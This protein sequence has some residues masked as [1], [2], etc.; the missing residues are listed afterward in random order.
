MRWFELPRT[1]WL[2]LLLLLLLP[3]LSLG[4]WQKAYERSGAEGRQQK[5]KQSALV[6]WL[7]RRRALSLSSRDP[8]KQSL[9][10]RAPSALKLTSGPSTVGPLSIGEESNHLRE[11]RAFFAGS[12]DDSF[13]F[14]GPLASDAEE[15]A[16]ESLSERAALQRRDRTPDILPL[17][18]SVNELNSS[19]S[20]S[21][22][23]VHLAEGVTERSTDPLRPPSVLSLSSAAASAEGGDATEGRG[24]E[25]EGQL[26]ETESL[27]RGSYASD[28]GCGM[29]G[30]RSEF[31]GCLSLRGIR[32]V[33]ATYSEFMKNSITNAISGWTLSILRKA[34][35]ETLRANKMKKGTGSYFSKLTVLGQVDD[36]EWVLDEHKATEKMRDEGVGLLDAELV[37]PPFHFDHIA[38][39]ALHGDPRFLRDV[40]E[41]LRETAW[42]LR[43]DEKVKKDWEEKNITPDSPSD[44]KFQS[45][46]WPLSLASIGCLNHELSFP[47]QP[48]CDPFALL[49]VPP[50]PSVLLELR[51]I[52]EGAVLSPEERERDIWEEKQRLDAIWNPQPKASA[53]LEET[54][55]HNVSF[56]S[57]EAKATDELLGEVPSFSFSEAKKQKAPKLFFYR[58]EHLISLA[59]SRQSFAVRFFLE[60]WGDHWRPRFGLP[61]KIALTAKFGPISMMEKFIQEWRDHPLLSKGEDHAD[62]AKSGIVKAAFCPSVLQTPASA[63]PVDILWKTWEGNDRVAVGQGIFSDALL[64]SGGV[65]Q[66]ALPKGN[67]LDALALTV[68]KLSDVFHADGTPVVRVPPPR[69]PS[70]GV[71]CGDAKPRKAGTAKGCVTAALISRSGFGTHQRNQ[72][73]P[74]DCG[75]GAPVHIAAYR[76]D[77]VALKTLVEF[78]ADIF[79]KDHLNRTVLHHIDLSTSTKSVGTMYLHVRSLALWQLGILGDETGPPSLQLFPQSLC[80]TSGEGTK[81]GNETKG[82]AQIHRLSSHQQQKSVIQTED[83]DCDGSRQLEVLLEE[84]AFG[85]RPGFYTFMRGR[86]WEAYIQYSATISQKPPKDWDSTMQMRASSTMFGFEPIGWKMIKSDLPA[87][88]GITTLKR[89]FDINP[90]NYSDSDQASLLMWALSRGYLEIV[91]TLWTPRQWKQKCK[92]C[93]FLLGLEDKNEGGNMMAGS[94]PIHIL[95]FKAHQLPDAGKMFTDLLA[96]AGDLLIYTPNDYGLRPIQMAAGITG[97]EELLFLMLRLKDRG[98]L[99]D[100]GGR[101]ELFSHMITDLLY[102]RLTVWQG[103]KSLPESVGVSASLPSEE[104]PL[105]ESVRVRRSQLELSRTVSDVMEDTLMMLLKYLRLYGGRVDPLF[106]SESPSNPAPCLLREALKA[107]TFLQRD[108]EERVELQVGQREGI[109]DKTQTT[110]EVSEDDQEDRDAAMEFIE[111]TG[112]GGSTQKQQTSRQVNLKKHESLEGSQKGENEDGRQGTDARKTEAGRET[113]TGTGNAVSDPPSHPDTKLNPHFFFR[114]EVEEG[115]VLSSEWMRVEVMSRQ[116]ALMNPSGCIDMD[117]AGAKN[118]SKNPKGKVGKNFEEMWNSPVEVDAPLIACDLPSALWICLKHPSQQAAAGTNESVCAQKDEDETSMESRRLNKRLRA[119]RCALLLRPF[120]SSS[121]LHADGG[122]RQAGETTGTFVEKEFEPEDG[123]ASGKTNEEKLKSTQQKNT[124][125]PDGGT[126]ELCKRRRWLPE[127]LGDTSILSLRHIYIG[128]KREEDSVLK[129]EGGVRPLLT[130]FSDEALLEG[131]RGED[132]EISEWRDEMENWNSALLVRLSGDMKMSTDGAPVALPRFE[133][134]DQGETTGNGTEAERRRKKLLKGPQ[135]LSALNLHTSRLVL[136]HLEIRGAPS[137]CV[138]A[139][140]SEVILRN[141]RMSR[142]GQAASDLGLFPIARDRHRGARILEPLGGEVEGTTELGRPLTSTHLSLSLKFTIDPKTAY[143]MGSALMLIYNNV[144]EKSSVIQDCVFEDNAGG[145]QG[146]AVSVLVGPSVAV[147]RTAGLVIERSTMRRNLARVKGGALAVSSF[148]KMPRAFHV[149]IR[150][151]LFE[152]NQALPDMARFEA[153]AAML[154]EAE[155]E[156]LFFDLK[157]HQDGQGDE[158]KTEPHSSSSSSS[159]KTPTMLAAFILATAKLPGGDEIPLG[160]SGAIHSSTRITQKIFEDL[161]GRVGDSFPSLEILN[162]TLRNNGATN[163][164]GALGAFATHVK[165]SECS[166]ENNYLDS[167]IKPADNVAGALS[168]VQSEKRA[169]GTGVHLKKCTFEGNQVFAKGKYMAT[170]APDAFSVRSHGTIEMSSGCVAVTDVENSVVARAEAS[171][172]SLLRLE[173]LMTVCPHGHTAQHDRQRTGAGAIRFRSECTQCESPTFLIGR[174]STMGFQ[175]GSSADQ[176]EAQKRNLEES[177]TTQ[178]KGGTGQPLSSDSASS[179][180]LSHVNRCASDC[181]LGASCRLGKNNVLA[182]PGFWC[183][184]TPPSSSSSSVD[185]VAVE[186]K[187]C[188][189]GDK[190]KCFPSYNTE[191]RC[192]EESKN[193]LKGITTKDRGGLSE[194][195]TSPSGFLQMPPLPAA[196]TQHLGGEVQASES[197]S[198]AFLGGSSR[199]WRA[200]PVSSFVSEGSTATRHPLGFSALESAQGPQAGGGNG[201]GSGISVR[202]SDAVKFD[203]TSSCHEHTDGPFCAECDQ[204]SGFLTFVWSLGG[205]FVC[206]QTC[207]RELSDADLLAWTLALGFSAL[208]RNLFFVISGASNVGVMKSLLFFSNAVLILDLAPAGSGASRIVRRVA[209]GLSFFLQMEGNGSEAA[210]GEKLTWWQQLSVLCAG[211]NFSSLHLLFFPL[212]K[213]LVFPSVLLVMLLFHFLFASCGSSSSSTSHANEGGEME[214]AEADRRAVQGPEEDCEQGEGQGERGALL[215]STERGGGSEEGSVQG[216]FEKLLDILDRRYMQ[217]FAFFVIDF[218]PTWLLLVAKALRCQDLPGGGGR[219]VWSAPV[220][221]CSALW[222]WPALGVLVLLALVPLGLFVFVKRAVTVRE[223]RLVRSVLQMLESCFKEKFNWWD[224]NFLLRRLLLVF[225]VSFVPGDGRQRALAQAVLAL[226][227]TAQTICEP[228]RRGLDNICEVTCLLILIFLCGLKRGDKATRAMAFDDAGENAGWLREI[229][230]LG[231]SVLLTVPYVFLAV[232]YVGKAQAAVSLSEGG[233]FLGA[234]GEGV[235]K[236]EESAKSS[237]SNSRRRELEEAGPAGR[238]GEKMERAVLEGRKGSGGGRD[239][240]TPAEGDM[241]R[242][243]SGQDKQA[244]DS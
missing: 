21:V 79:R 183:V 233:D 117:R 97:T 243:L 211:S 60:A 33:D 113:R 83:A 130:C 199:Q 134:G 52:I 42:G 128:P 125:G 204:G 191:E 170:G 6:R 166:F 136:D 29:T 17:S 103:E 1:V 205:T 235:L 151:S 51:E 54:G 80:R 108:A 241:E 36:P 94:L 28:G 139:I 176:F 244:A 126:F 110:G 120:A 76:G 65:F 8:G 107:R 9:S 206:H 91:R 161:A 145:F 217:V 195:S 231:V 109:D 48:R 202:C 219:V 119:R 180:S 112:W 88:Q 22:P 143:L 212:W 71:C 196:L 122:R 186:C 82:E 93:R 148:A 84:D 209:M 192:R 214:E 78:G 234:G 100:T 133:L 75:S 26:E 222:W 140:D 131:K 24:N 11:R 203:G 10:A 230:L 38:L 127:L 144:A 25:P 59:I 172:D 30:L 184:H 18:E 98:G 223:W 90:D 115:A 201:G 68:R 64:D 56:L 173:G 43:E 165:L 23:A 149:D 197:A 215:G 7:Q 13:R 55:K 236:E 221:G 220:Q 208:A 188:P 114:G 73:V 106:L 189:P 178:R 101:A 105:R 152:G 169:W 187:E 181:P 39:A 160:S 158:T 81:G 194:V 163:Q 16:T 240:G 63:A 87:M 162:C 141:V 129:W 164:A 15:G 153:A 150:D 238:D 154:K 118:K 57:E 175:T 213:T 185:T 177:Q 198:R 216:P 135:I 159:G 34:D 104:L 58:A 228:F 232:H 12:G 207:G 121:E 111:E 167:L 179:L 89:Y 147:Y 116:E 124:A 53:L 47:G 155:D 137:F 66:W 239:G 190:G 225:V 99:K 171:T 72:N 67:L 41:V 61:E 32:E 157:S 218:Y 5:Q 2:C 35:K 49:R 44:I 200:P 210:V 138:F 96:L 20:E 193:N 69:P 242:T 27:G 31:G 237:G 86:R 174:G 50:D 123:D 62:C 156:S 70:P 132:R 74:C 102:E 45:D 19:S 142:C 227:L 4:G 224:S 85:T 77:S 168:V 95:A 226:T 37:I 40:V 146:G 3:Q 92:K 14:R 182:L 229:D 46:H